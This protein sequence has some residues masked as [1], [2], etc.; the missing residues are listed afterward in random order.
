VIAPACTN[1]RFIEERVVV[2]KNNEF[3]KEGKMISAGYS[4]YAWFMNSLDDKSE[5]MLIRET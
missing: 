2:T 3:W 5:S 1:D 4:S